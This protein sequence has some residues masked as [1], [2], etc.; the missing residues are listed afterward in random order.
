MNRN[1]VEEKE[2][3]IGREFLLIC[4]SNTL[5]FFSIYL[6]IPVLPLFLE[7]VKGYSNTLIGTLM[8]MLLVAALLRPYLGRASDV[9]G[10]KALLVLGTLLLCVT[11]LLYAA[12]TTAA[13]LFLVRFVNGLGLAAFHTA[14][15]ALIGDLVPAARRLHGIA[16]F[17]ISIDGAIG[18]APLVAE[19]IRKVWGYNAVYYLAG[20]LALLAFIT[21]TFI[22]ETKR[23]SS[24]VAK[25]KRAWIMPGPLQRAIFLAT[26]GYTLTL[27]A[28]STFVVLS[29]R[30]VSID[31]GE[32]FFTIFAATLITFRLVVGKRADWWPRKPLIMI[33]GIIVLVGLTVI[34]FSGSLFL[35]ILG[36]LIYALGFAYV[37]TTLSALLLD[38]T[39]V[40]ERGA[41]LGFFMAIFDLG[42]GLGGVAMGPIADA[43]GYQAMYM[44]G[45]AIALLSL[46]YFLLRISHPPVEDTQS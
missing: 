34:A 25:N 26:M 46:L 5:A 41:M 38:N 9:R 8:S 40:S 42:I 36:C 13:P 11:N 12:F 2:R 20:V 14:S 6:I 17:F 32:L 24:P 15:Y 28:L 33:S 23:E 7:E 19:L 35:F 16:L 43:W 31:A 44:A 37:P 30:D 3:L 27:G 21:S 1:E 39:P 10:R 29:T 45:A 18:G 22:R 4:G